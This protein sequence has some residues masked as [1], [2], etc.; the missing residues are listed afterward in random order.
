M[1]AGV[2]MLLVAGACG[3]EEA[4]SWEGAYPGQLS[5]SARFAV[6]GELRVQGGGADNAEL[7]IAEVRPGRYRL[8]MPGCAAEADVDGERLHLDPRT[9]CACVAGEARAEATVAG[10]A[11]RPGGQLRVRLE[12]TTAEGSCEWSFTARP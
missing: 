11:T 9:H 7:R 5:R 4:R 2:L 12:G 1:R 6:D 8:E 3:G 10:E